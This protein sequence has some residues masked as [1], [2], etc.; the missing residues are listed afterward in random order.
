M[1]KSEYGCVYLIADAHR[2]QR[3]F[4]DLPDLQHQ[5]VRNLLIRVQESELGSPGRAARDLKHRIFSQA[6]NYAPL[7]IIR[8]MS[9]KF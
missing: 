8:Y 5:V 7:K 1:C 3:M 2:G 6:L 4:S 9:F